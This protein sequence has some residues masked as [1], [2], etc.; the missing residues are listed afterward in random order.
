MLLKDIE[1]I[2]KVQRSATKFIHSD[3]T[4]DYRTKLTQ[5]GML[6]LM[7]IYETSDIFFFDQ[8]T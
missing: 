1:L 8:I 7:Y 5:L 6:P 2:V 3:Y 4:S